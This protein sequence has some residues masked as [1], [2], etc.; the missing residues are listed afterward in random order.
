MNEPFSIA[1]SPEEYVKTSQK[2]IMQGIITCEALENAVI[3]EY[4]IGAK[5][6][7]NLFWS[8]LTDEI[9]LLGFDRRIQT[10]LDGVLDLPAHRTVRAKHSHSKH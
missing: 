7:A 9:D 3:E 8:P 2:R 4:V 5:F 6:N 10:D 1:S